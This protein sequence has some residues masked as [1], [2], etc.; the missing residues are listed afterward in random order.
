MIAI[1]LLCEYST[2]LAMKNKNKNEKKEKR[3]SREK[4]FWAK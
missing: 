1:T 3:S 2:Y 4:V